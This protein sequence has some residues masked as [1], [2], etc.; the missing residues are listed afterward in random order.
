MRMRLLVVVLGCVVTAGC[1][2]A[3]RPS[4]A[5]ARANHAPQVKARCAPCRIGPGQSLT[6]AAAASDADGD[7][8]TYAWAAAAG[9]LATP[10]AAD[11]AFTA[12]AQPG[13]IPIAVTVRD[14]RGGI[15]SDTITI[16]VTR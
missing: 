6:V 16:T 9:T 13:A 14:G 5:P 3:P 11:S 4:V 10:T 8:V 12:P 7:A 1:A 2:T 15:A